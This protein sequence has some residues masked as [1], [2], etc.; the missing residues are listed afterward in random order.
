MFDPL[1]PLL[2]TNL[3]AVVAVLLLLWLVS[4]IIDD[5][6]MI[7]AFW[8]LGFVLIA[9][10]SYAVGEG[11]GARNQLIAWLVTIWGVRL[12]LHLFIRWLRVGPDHRYVAMLSN[13]KINRHLY[14]LT[15]VFLLQAVLILIVALPVQMGATAVEEA[16]TGPLHY[17]GVTLWAFGFLFETVGDYQLHRFRSNP[18]NYDLTLRTGLW[19][20]TRHPNYFGDLCVWWGIYLLVADT[21]V[22]I[23][24]FIGPL[25]L[26]IMLFKWSGV[27]VVE[28]RLNK[29]RADYASYA[30]NTSALIPWPPKKTKEIK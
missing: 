25:L 14:A 5:V 17:A 22:G 6:S 11:D 16:S 4:I 24:A 2:L 15:H 19:R 30:A 3:T 1:W 12:A 26:T 28:N 29:S 21:G 23:Y 20:Y 27:R 10:I 8:G 7:D 18:E 9:W 13:T